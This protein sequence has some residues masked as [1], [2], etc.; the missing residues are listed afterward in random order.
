MR[1]SKGDIQGRYDGYGYHEDS[2]ERN[3]PRA[4]Q[5]GGRNGAATESRRQRRLRKRDRDSDPVDELDDVTPADDRTSAVSSFL[6]D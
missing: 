4:V 3:R 1:P 5:D 2:P 6:R